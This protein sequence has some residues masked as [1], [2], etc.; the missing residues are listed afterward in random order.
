MNPLGRRQLAQV[1]MDSRHFS[2]VC[3]RLGLTTEV[4]M[5]DNASDD[6]DVVDL[7]TLLVSVGSY[8]VKIVAAPL[9]RC[10][11]EKHGDMAADCS[12]TSVAGRSMLVQMICEIMETLVKS[13]FYLIK[14]SAVEDMIVVVET[15]G[16][17]ELRV[18]WLQKRLE[19]ILNT[20]KAIEDFSSIEK[21]RDA[22]YE[23]LLDS[24]KVLQCYRDR[25]ELR[26]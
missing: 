17:L 23:L 15:L 9:L 18:G 16:K 21:A 10:I 2:I 6:E 25:I 14:E 24:I 11:I 4:H 12:L 20:K 8:V 7:S 13:E 26:Y 1:K 5:L 22:K 19:E 3:R